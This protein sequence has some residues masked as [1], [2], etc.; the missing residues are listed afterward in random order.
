[1]F[2]VAFWLYA[3]EQ[4]TDFN[5]DLLSKKFFDFIFDNKALDTNLTV[6]DKI[7]TE[8]YAVAIRVKNGR[9]E[10]WRRDIMA[11]IDYDLLFS[12][13]ETVFRLLMINYCCIKYMTYREDAKLIEYLDSKLSVNWKDIDLVDIRENCQKPNKAV[14]WKG[15]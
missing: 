8:A 15:N 14:F 4:F 2:L 1:M 7:D 12:R 13:Q 3:H 9:E 6:L 10:K 5:T 11:S